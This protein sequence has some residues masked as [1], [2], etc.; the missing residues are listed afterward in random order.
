MVFKDAVIR[1]FL[2]SSGPHLE[3]KRS[4]LMLSFASIIIG[5]VL[6]EVQNRLSYQAIVWPFHMMWHF[7]LASSAYNTRIFLYLCRIG[8]NEKIPA[9]LGLSRKKLKTH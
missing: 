5:K 7:F 3:M 4:V 9:S 6:W 1:H 2:K 8:G